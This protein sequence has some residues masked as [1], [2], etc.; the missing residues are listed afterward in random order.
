MR[1]V[2]QSRP[3]TP[4]CVV[5]GVHNWRFYKGSLKFARLVFA[6]P[7]TRLSTSRFTVK[8]SAKAEMRGSRIKNCG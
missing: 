3:E 8:V 6:V 4:F 7:I 2:M 5:Q 1:L